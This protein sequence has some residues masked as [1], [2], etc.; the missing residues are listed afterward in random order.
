MPTHTASHKTND[1]SYRALHLEFWHAM[2]LLILL[3]N[4][5]FGE[6]CNIKEKLEVKYK[7]AFLKMKTMNM[8]SLTKI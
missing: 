3:M 2:N 5:K 8:I 4:L 7:L 1:N 6:F